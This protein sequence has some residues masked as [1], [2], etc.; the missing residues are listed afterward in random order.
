MHFVYWEVKNIMIN[1]RWRWFRFEWRRELRS[2]RIRRNIFF[3]IFQYMVKVFL[4][5]KLVTARKDCPINR[6]LLL[7]YSSTS[8]FYW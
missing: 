8:I 5:I 1:R 4:Y 3:S 2:I 7:L 6:S